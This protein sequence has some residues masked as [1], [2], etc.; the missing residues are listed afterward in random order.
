MAAIEQFTHRETFLRLLSIAGPQTIVIMENVS[1]YALLSS[2]K[3]SCLQRLRMA[4]T[5]RYLIDIAPFTQHVC[6]LYLPWSYLDREILRYSN[7]YAFQY[8]HGEMDAAGNIRFAHDFDLLAEKL[9]P[10]SAIEFDRFLPGITFQDSTVSAGE[11][12]RYAAYKEHL[13]AAYDNPRKIVTELCDCAN[14][15]GSR[16]ESLAG[17]L[18]GE[19]GHA[20]VYTNIVKNN[21]LIRQALRRMG[22]K[23]LPEIRTYMTHDCRPIEAEA[24]VL[25]ET[26]INANRVAALDVLSDIAPGSRVYMMRN[27][28]KADQLVFGETW[29]EWTAIDGLVRELWR[30]QCQGSI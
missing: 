12:A 1:R 16:Y 23:R 2:D 21:P 24:V 5:R 8:N 6:K 19:T 15:M 7:G 9:A 14:M 17:V 18:E 13:F 11:A 26:P 30:V 29:A 25:F 22:V 3:F 27:D 10:H 28:T 20:V 4:T